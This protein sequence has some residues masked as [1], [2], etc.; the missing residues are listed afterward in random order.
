MDFIK[1]QGLQVSA[2]A[3]DRRVDS[4]MLLRMIFRI[5]LKVLVKFEKVTDPFS[6]SEENYQTKKKYDYQ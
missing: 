1:A 2:I 6:D 3:N 5:I 4:G